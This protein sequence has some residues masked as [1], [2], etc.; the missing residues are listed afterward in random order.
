MQDNELNQ[1]GQKQNITGDY[2][3]FLKGPYDKREKKL[4]LMFFVLF[5][6]D[7]FATGLRTTNSRI[8]WIFFRKLGKIARKRELESGHR[9]LEQ[10]TWT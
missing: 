3:V 10:L 6:F 2:T 9:K 4:D 7:F 1:I 8:T 5:R